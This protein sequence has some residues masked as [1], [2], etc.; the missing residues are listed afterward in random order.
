[1][2]QN[3]AK[4]FNRPQLQKQDVEDIYSAL[5][6][7]LYENDDYDISRACEGFGGN[8][9]TLEQYVSSCVKNCVQHFC[10][11][12]KSRGKHEQQEK[13]FEDADGKQVSQFEFAE[14]PSVKQEFLKLDYNLTDL[15]SQYECFRYR[16]G[17]DMFQLIYVRLLLLQMNKN[18]EQLYDNIMTILGVNKK[19]LQTVWKK[20]AGTDIFVQILKAA[21]EIGYIEAVRTLEQFVYGAADIKKAVKSQV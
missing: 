20:Q 12:K 15:C 11:E 10:S 18:N 17:C 2:I 4:M 21:Y 16:F 14:D 19:Q 1:M 13:V 9:I 6:E 3:S 7:Y 8:V 5:G